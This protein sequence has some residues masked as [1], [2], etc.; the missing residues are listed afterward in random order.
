M[1]CVFVDEKSQHLGLKKKVNLSPQIAVRG[2]RRAAIGSESLG[3]SG[4]WYSRIMHRPNR[5]SDFQW[6]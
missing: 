3:R 4:I 6:V 2:T 5:L 1:V